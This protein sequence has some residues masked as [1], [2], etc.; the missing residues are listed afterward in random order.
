M[1]IQSSMTSLPS[2]LYSVAQIRQIEQLAIKTHAIAGAELMARAGVASFHVVKHHFPQIKKIII[3]CGKGNNGGDGYVLARLAHEAGINVSLYS[4]CQIE[5]LPE[6]ARIAA[7]H[8]LQAGL[9][10]QPF[11]D[12]I[13]ESADLIVDAI[14][15][16]GIHGTVRGQALTAIEVLN[17]LDIPVLA[18]DIPSGLNADTGGVCGQAVKAALTVTFIG[19]KQ[20]LLTAN[21][22]AYC[23]KLYCDDLNL[24]FIFDEVDISAY[25]VDW[26]RLRH[27]LLPRARDA[28]KG[29][30]GHV[31]IVG[32]DYGMAGAVRMAGEAAAR[33]GAGL[34]TVATRLEHIAAVIAMRPELMCYPI[35]DSKALLPLLTRANVVVLGPGLGDSAWSQSL[36]KTV[37]ASDL[38]LVVDASALALLARQPQHRDRWILTPHPGEAARLLGT[39]AQYIQAD[40]FA[41]AVALQQKL[42]GVIVLKGAGT[43]I[44]AGNELPSVCVEGNPGMASGGMG[45][46]LS[47]VIGGF[48]AQGF[49]LLT[50]ARMG[51]CLHAH[52]GDKAAKQGERG[53]LATDLMPYLR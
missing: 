39:S 36:L 45:D 42:G 43:I 33:V 21:A 3:V 34:V 9:N 14:L 35:A 13:K 40:R 47:G 4:L 41:N 18:I 38:P 1:N 15:G 50:A 52:A 2:A 29:N 5:D 17:A 30:F 51:V 22:P 16:I 27:K 6:T 24:A 32:G 53:L 37:L 12:E 49:D 20:G 46:V 44:Q 23:G 25:H 7:T 11:V 48:V 26:W 10:I 19:V 31:L 28:H 8:C